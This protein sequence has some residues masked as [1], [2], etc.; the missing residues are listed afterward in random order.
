MQ[1]RE[2]GQSLR[3]LLIEDDEDDYILIQRLLCQVFPSGLHL[4]WAHSYDAGLEELKRK[5]HD[6]YLFDYRL[7]HRSGLE[8]LKELGMRDSHAPVI[9]LTGHGDYQ[10]DLEAMR[11][12]ASD[13][14]VKGQI[15]ADLLERSIRYA[16]DRKRAED[17][18]RESE[19]QLKFLSSQLLSV[20]EIERK[21]IAGALHDNL[22]QIL[23][24]IKFRV[25]N[26]LNQMQKGT[27][28]ARSLE[29]VIPLTRYAI[30]EVR[31]MYTYL[32]PTILDDFGIVATLGWLGREFESTHVNIAVEYEF[33]I[34][35]N[36]IPE[37]LKT[38]IFR[39]VQEALD[40]IEK[41]SKAELVNVFLGKGNDT[42]ELIIEDNGVGFDV[43]QDFPENINRK[44]LGLTSM[45]ERAELSGGS[46]AIESTIGTGTKIHVSWPLK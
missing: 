5:Q 4:D 40:N 9:F 24:A 21:R 28:A 33:D 35:E 6:V 41:H 7:G 39:I 27:E 29:S 17:A 12:G 22:G 44:G 31:K 23:S 18:L 37:V 8:L 11:A 34:Q 26:A 25:E 2:I 36:E 14:L 13:Y 3:I 30:E 32:R 16:V 10:V 1:A 38:A 43:G 19:T 15:T 42:V 46:F 45:K 20:Q